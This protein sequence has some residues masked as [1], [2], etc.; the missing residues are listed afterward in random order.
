MTPPEYIQLKAFARIDGALLSL[1]FVAAFACYVVGLKSPVYGLLALLTIV[2]TPVFVVVRL[3]RFRDEAL[4]GKISFR[5]AWFYVALMFG[6]GGLLFA[7]AQYAYLA[8]LDQGYMLMVITEMLS[9]A[10]TAELINQMGMTDQISES[11]HVLQNTRP[12]DFALNMLMTVVLSGTMLGMPIAAV[13]QKKE[14][15]IK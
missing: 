12:I 2:L 11:L 9:T 7:L 8:Y 5:R 6:Y 15:E 1:L 14:K 4:L 10:E 13:M 3:K